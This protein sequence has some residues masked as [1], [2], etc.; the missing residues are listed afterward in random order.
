MKPPTHVLI[1]P[2]Q[3]PMDL[4]VGHVRFM[5]EELLVRRNVCFH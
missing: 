4:R 1:L 5:D 2:T 3:I